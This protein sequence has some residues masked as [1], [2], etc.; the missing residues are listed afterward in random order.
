VGQDIASDRMNPAIAAL[1]VPAPAPRFPGH[2]NAIGAAPVWIRTVGAGESL[3]ARSLIRRL[4]EE[5]LPP[6]TSV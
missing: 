5:H 3:L 2:D 6:T 1:A 4:I